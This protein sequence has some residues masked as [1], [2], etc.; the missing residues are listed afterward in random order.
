MSFNPSAT[1]CYVDAQSTTDQIQGALFPQ[2]CVFPVLLKLYD[3]SNH[4]AQQR[5]SRANKQ[6]LKTP[7]K[8]RLYQ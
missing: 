1:F 7:L 2:S 8:Y 4:Y 3:S 6:T 5:V